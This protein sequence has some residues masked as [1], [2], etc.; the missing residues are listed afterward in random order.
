ME[1]CTQ[2]E[3]AVQRNHLFMTWIPKWT[4]YDFPIAGLQAT[5]K[6]PDNIRIY[7]SG[8]KL[9]AFQTMIKEGGE[10]PASDAIPQTSTMYCKSI[11]IIPRVDRPKNWSTDECVKAYRH[12]GSQLLPAQHVEQ[13]LPYILIH[14]RSGDDNTEARDE[15]PFCTRLVIQRLH[16][17]GVYMKVISNNH[18]F[19]MSWL[20]GLPSIHL[21]H[22]KSPYQDILLALSAAAI[23]QHASTG[24]SSYTSVPAMAKGIPLINTFTG[25]NHRF[26]L[27]RKHGAVPS[28]F[29]ACQDLESFVLLAVQSTIKA[30]E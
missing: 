8:Q 4:G 28:E 19:S 22:T 30:G 18:S 21:V 12:A 24:W 23:V 1:W 14:F 27:F 20:T 15:T 26:D 16:A 25:K 10:L 5:L 7:P 17:Q 29:Y 13:D 9:P 2:P 11:T 6:L 3:R